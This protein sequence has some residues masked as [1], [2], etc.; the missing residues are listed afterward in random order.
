MRSLLALL[1]TASIGLLLLAV[2][3]IDPV[4]PKT[5]AVQIVEPVGGAQPNEEDAH[6]ASGCSL[7]DHP[8]APFTE[9]QFFETLEQYA[10]QPHH[11]PSA[12]L[13]RLLFY[14]RRTRELIDYHGLERLP[15]TH[16]RVLSR[17]LSRTHA[18]VAIR[19]VDDRGSTRAELPWTRV[20]FGKKQHLRPRVK[21]IQAMSFNGTVMRTGLGHIWARY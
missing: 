12:P 9:T 18:R 8:V 4:A 1:T 13:E 21:R 2:T 7:K 15:K 14:G 5:P 3:F 11:A 19:V 16:R 6:C 17:E 10:K 20:P